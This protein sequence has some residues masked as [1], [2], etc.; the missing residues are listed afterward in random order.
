MQEATSPRVRSVDVARDTA[1]V[2]RDGFDA[3][4][5]A[6]REISR[7][8]QGRFETA[9]WGGHLADARERLEL[10][11]LCLHAVLDQVAAVMGTD[12]ANTAVWTAA[13]G[14]YSESLAGH[15]AA[16]IAET[17][18]NSVT[19]RVLGTVGVNPNVEFLDYQFARISGPLAHPS[20]HVRS[21]ASETATAVQDLLGDAGF[22]LPFEDAAR[23]ARLI[24]QRIEARWAA[25]GAPV[26]IDGLEMLDPVFFRRKG[27]YLI[28]RVVGGNRAMPLL[29]PIVHG[30]G[31]LRVDAVLLTE[32]D[33][34]I[35]FS[36]T[37]SYFHADIPYPNDVIAFLHALMP[38]KPLA[39]LYTALGYHRHGKTEFYRDLQR[40][41]TRTNERFDFAP[42]APGMVMAVFAMPGY[43]VVF[44]IIRDSFP[45]PKQTTPDEVR[46]RYELVFAHDRAGR[47]VD[48]QE[49]EGLAFP[50]GRFTRRLLDELTQTAG[51]TVRIE[52]DSVEVAHLY[53]E[54]RVRPLDLHLAD[55]N[56]DE[57]RRVALDYGQAIRDL[58]ATNVFP[59]DL[60]LKNF[61]V[62]RHGR[63]VF[64]D[65]D[66]LR[67][68]TECRFRVIPPPRHPE[69]EMSDEPW[70][71]VGPEDVFPEDLRRFVPF[72]SAIR[73]SYLAAHA[74]LYESAFWQDLQTQNAGG[75][76]L[77]VY[78]YPEERRLHG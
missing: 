15:P 44:K 48:A 76:V 69:D 14:R 27:A 78:P 13:R 61:G 40:H 20:V 3:Y 64:Y 55:A 45:P 9:D 43:D 35:V 26:P 7:R 51:R 49:F 6:F 12:C 75:A 21:V 31:G 2:I 28:G 65:Y 50:K 17:F 36:F 16:E 63:V 56:P 62:T 52:G 10:Y 1:A 72:G 39:E 23:D 70:F 22:A 11:T 25:G 74:A 4:Q 18:F 5:D 67:L 41:L 42:G 68:L 47:L 19:R 53:T 71:H 33:A 54:R 58:A 46:R 57:A 77:D 73:E 66:E 34:S 30:P 32:E 38:A 24:A 29:L 60:L 8:A 59:G 37:R